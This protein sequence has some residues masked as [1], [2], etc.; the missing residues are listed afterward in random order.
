VKE[1]PAFV[2][3]DLGAE[4][5][6]VVLGTLGDGSVTLD[7]VSRFPNRALTLPDGLHWDIG[8]L[9]RE[10]LTGL[11]LAARAHDVRSVA[12]DSWGVDYGFLDE[13]GHLLGLPFHYRDRRTDGIAERV[14]EQ[15]AAGRAFPTTGIQQM[16]INTV[17][18]LLAEDES[19]ALQA[20]HRIALIPDLLAFWLCGVVAN[21]RTDASTTGLLDAQTG[22]WARDLIDTIG[23]PTRIFGDL[24]DPAT[25]LGPLLPVHVEALGLDGEVSVVATAG[26]DTASA[27]AGAPVS[28]Q[29]AAVLSSGTWSL[30]GV[31]LDGPVLTEA[32]Q[33]AGLSNERGVFGTVRLLRNVMGLWLLQQ[34]RA[35]W[36]EG[37]A[38]PEY[39]ELCGL[40]AACSEEPALFDPDHPSLVHPGDMP[41]RIEALV[42][43]GGQE[44]PQG[45]GAV[46]NSIFVSLACKY[47]LV[48][49]QLERVT[50]RSIQDIHVVGGGSRNELLCRL[51][52]DITGR[53]V[54]AGPAEASALGNILTQACA[55]GQLSGLDEMREISR[56]SFPAVRH[57]PSADRRKAEATYKRFLALT[58]L[59]TQDVRAPQTQGRNK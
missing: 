34:C 41:A 25:S 31:E 4:S 15:M 47:R 39:E 52:A 18:Q 57:R 53:D 43:A 28:G 11:G 56:T 59:G 44:V 13:R 22:C 24:V 48:L 27:F 23:L 8:G 49:E 2:A 14:A 16:P 20:A 21:E 1:R 9:F 5:G 29:G 30:L 50:S 38:A 32:A 33:A 54:L 58:S 6:R 40:A 46:V 10:G 42:R 37:E 55:M 19:A 36:T 17:Y 35:T 51:T 7:E 3:I 12:V 45:R 26:H